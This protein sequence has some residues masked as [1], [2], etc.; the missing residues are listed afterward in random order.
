MKKPR[1]VHAFRRGCANVPSPSRGAPGS[2]VGGVCVARVRTNMTAQGGS[3]FW[4]AQ[5]LSY[6]RHD[7][8][9]KLKRGQQ[10]LL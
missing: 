4:F 5:A 1:A 6:L 9:V 7:R 3:G 10:H 8:D 2:A